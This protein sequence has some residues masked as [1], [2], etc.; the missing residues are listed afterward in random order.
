MHNSLRLRLTFFLKMGRKVW[1]L[2]K[3]L[4]RPSKDPRLI[5]CRRTKNKIM[6]KDENIKVS[7]MG[8]A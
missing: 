5:R 8:V 6:L 7:M 3:F 4:S 1:Q 2:A